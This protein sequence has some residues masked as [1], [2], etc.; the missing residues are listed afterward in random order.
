MMTMMMVAPGPL[1]WGQ[2][3]P[4]LSFLKLNQLQNAHKATR[5]SLCATFK[6]L[7]IARRHAMT[8]QPVRIG[9][10]KFLC[11]RTFEFGERDGDGIR[12][13]HQQQQTVRRQ[14]MA[15]EVKLISY[16]E[17]NFGWCFLKKETEGVSPV[18]QH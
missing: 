18:V 2:L 8:A 9:H 1:L 4:C 13:Q 14:K 15:S 3:L 17:P 7:L 6:F 5:H 12:E 11:C 10:L 16:L